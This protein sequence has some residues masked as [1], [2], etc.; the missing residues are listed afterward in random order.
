MSRRRR[1]TWTGQPKPKDRWR[2]LTPLIYKSATAAGRFTVPRG[3][4]T[5]FSS[6]PRLPLA[7]LLAGNTADAAG[8]VHDYLYRTARETRAVADAVYSE[9]MREPVRFLGTL[10]VELLDI[11]PEPAWRR[12]LMWLAVRLGGRR[13]YGDRNEEPLTQSNA[14]VVP[15]EAP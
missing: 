7:Y 1:T 11:R 14:V 10:R 15:P 12:G 5:D 4:T 9:A 6:V 8:V 2:L 13:A 3:F